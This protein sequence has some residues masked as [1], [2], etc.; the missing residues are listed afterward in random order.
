MPL[1]LGDEGPAVGPPDPR[2]LVVG[3]GDDAAA[4]RAK[5]GGMDVVR[6]PLELG[7]EGAGVGHPDPRRLVLRRGDDAAAVRAERRGNDHLRM[8]DNRFQA[9]PF[10]DEE[11]QTLTYF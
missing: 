10:E 1:E 7:E 9:R 11:S 3:S 8:F 6:M 5:R 4:L 2:R